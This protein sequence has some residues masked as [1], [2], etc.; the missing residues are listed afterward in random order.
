MG[1]VH[2]TS[3]YLKCMM[4][5]VMACGAT[6]AAICPLDIVKCRKQASPELYKSIPDGF[7]KIMAEEGLKGFSIVSNTPSQLG[8][9]PAGSGK[10]AARN[11]EFPVLWAARSIRGIF[12]NSLSGLVP[13][14]RWIRRPGHVQVRL[15]RDVQGRLPRRRRPRQRCQVPDRRLRGLLRL[16]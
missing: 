12:A 15:L 11:A 4:G 13:H 16:R 3:Y 8:L 5:G 7:K 2:D 1:D 9:P 6:H 14:P 10:Q